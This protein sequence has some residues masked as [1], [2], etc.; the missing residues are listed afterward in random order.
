LANSFAN[1]YF[2]KYLIEEFKNLDMSD[3]KN[4]EVK[5]C[6]AIC[7][8][9]KYESSYLCIDTLNIYRDLLGG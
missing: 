3:I 8:F 7:S 2:S 1:L 9:L 6:H 5:E 4:P